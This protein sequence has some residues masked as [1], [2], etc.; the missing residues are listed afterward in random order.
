MFNIRLRP[1]Y[2]IKQRVCMN[3]KYNRKYGSCLYLLAYTT[4]KDF[5]KQKYK[6]LRKI[7][8]MLLC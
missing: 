4:I 2:T 1:S 8:Y 6:N 5:A 3:I 7:L